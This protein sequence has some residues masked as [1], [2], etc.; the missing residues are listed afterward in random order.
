MGGKLVNSIGLISERGVQ[1]IEE[2]FLISA[3]NHNLIIDKI[4]YICI[5][6]KIHAYMYI[7]C[8]FLAFL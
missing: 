6:D 2:I 5:I 3:A 4:A 1:D 8:I 7:H